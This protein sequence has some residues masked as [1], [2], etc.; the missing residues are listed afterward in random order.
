LPESF[1]SSET[2]CEVSG[3]GKEK[4]NGNNYLFKVFL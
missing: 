3:W 2:K 1:D 4:E